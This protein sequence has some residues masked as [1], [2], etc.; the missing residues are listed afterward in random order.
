MGLGTLAGSVGGG[1][2]ASSAADTSGSTQASRGQSSIYAPVFVPQGNGLNIGELL[3]PYNEAGPENGGYAGA[4]TLPTPALSVGAPSR[5][6]LLPIVA[7]VAAVAV[8]ALMLTK[9][10]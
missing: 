3:K 9:G 1:L 6:G 7:V 5:W 4:G 2:S 10:K 8:G